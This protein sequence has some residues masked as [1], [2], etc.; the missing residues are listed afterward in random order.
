MDSCGSELKALLEMTALCTEHQ[1]KYEDLNKTLSQKVQQM[2]SYLVQADKLASTLN[3]KKPSR[4]EQEHLQNLQNLRDFLIESPHADPELA[5]QRQV[6][7]QFQDSF[8]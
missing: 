8:V 5:Q 1:A 7:A 6:C 3:P 2:Q 4:Q